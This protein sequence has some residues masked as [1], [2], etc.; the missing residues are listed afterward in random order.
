MEQLLV[1]IIPT[2]PTV[3]LLGALSSPFRLSIEMKL[4]EHVLCLNAYPRADILTRGFTTEA[5]PRIDSDM[6]G[7]GGLGRGTITRATAGPHDSNLANKADPRVDSDLDGKHG[8]G[9]GATTGG[10]KGVG[11]GSGTTVGGAH[12]GPGSTDIT[13][14]TGTTG[15]TSSTTGPHKSSLLNKLDPR[16]DSDKDGSRLK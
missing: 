3:S 14:N 4:L 5:D 6:D 10:S 2:W 7:K 1:L 13:G 9:S 8:L 12:S 11:L 16:V 15:Q